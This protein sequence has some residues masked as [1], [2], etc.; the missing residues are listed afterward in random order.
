MTMPKTRLAAGERQLEIVRAVLTLSL[1]HILNAVLR[2]APPQA[3]F[4]VCGPPRL[5]EGAL[6]TADALGIDPSR[7]QCESFT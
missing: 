6:Q 7:I 1:I 3:V 2:C 4:Y 5:I